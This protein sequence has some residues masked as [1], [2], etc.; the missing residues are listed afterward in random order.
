MSNIVKK[1]S[2]GKVDK[3]KK[4]LDDVLVYIVISIAYAILLLKGI[5]LL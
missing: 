4:K 3:E 2:S 5:G 1:Q